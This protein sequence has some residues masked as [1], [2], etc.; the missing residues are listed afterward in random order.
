M[1]YALSIWLFIFCYCYTAVAWAN[2]LSGLNIED[3]QKEPSNKIQWQ[4][5]PFVQNLDDVSVHELKLMA[6]VYREGDAA[7]LISGQV[8]RQGDKIGSSELVSIEKKGVIL[9]NE[10]G[11]FRLSLQGGKS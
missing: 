3:F 2:T 5:N 10:H 7:C 11:I 9:R 4:N 8:L 1:R 6:I